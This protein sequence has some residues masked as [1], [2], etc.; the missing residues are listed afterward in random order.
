RVFGFHLQWSVPGKILTHVAGAIGVDE[1]GRGPL[2]GPVL[3]AAVRLPSGF[4]VRGINDSKAL[5]RERREQLAIR[6]KSDAEFQLIEVGLEAIA[7]RNI[8]HA[9]LD[10][11]E[12]AAVAL[13][14]QEDRILVDGDKVP[15]GLRHRAEA[16]V[17]GD[18][19]FACIAAASILAKTERDRIMTDFA[20]EYPEYGFEKHFGYATPEHLAALHEHGPCPIH[21]VTFRPICD[22][23]A[24]PCLTFD[25]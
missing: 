11:M 3:V 14:P 19:T 5:D 22:M 21:R 23:L 15:F 25:A 18:A 2:A 20:Q 17:D 4:D 6:I 9:T 8:L 10:A 16:I 1:A 12:A 13:K 24:Q 7:K